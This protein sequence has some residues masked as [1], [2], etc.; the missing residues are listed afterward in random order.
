VQDSR[1]GPQALLRIQPGA[2]L[3]RLYS[4]NIRASNAAPA[5]EG[6]GSTVHIENCSFVSNNGSAIVVV[7]HPPSGLVHV[8]IRS[9][10]FRGNGQSD[11]SGG[12][13]RVDGPSRGT[14][15]VI[16]SSSFTANRAH[17][18]GA[19]WVGG[20][21]LVQVLRCLFESNT[22]TDRGGALFVNGNALVAAGSG[23][24]LAHNVANDGRSAFLS[25]QGSAAYVLP[26]PLGHW[27]SS[28]VSCPVGAVPPE[29]Q[30]CPPNA[31]FSQLLRGALDD[32]F[33][34]RCGPGFVGNSLDVDAQDGPD[35]ATQ[36]PA[37][38]FC[39]GGTVYPTICGT[40]T[41]CGPGSPFATLCPP[42]TYGSRD[43]LRS[44][45]ECTDCEP[46]FYCRSG[47]R[48]DCGE[49]FYNAISGATT[50][51]E[52]TRCPRFSTTR[53]T[54]ANQSS[55]C[56]C[57][58]GYY[59]SRTRQA[60]GSADCKP[61]GTGMNCSFS[62]LGTTL[63]TLPISRGYWRPSTSSIDIRRCPDASANCTDR[64]N[65]TTSG[66]RGGP[67]ESLYCAPG[68]HG[69]FCELCMRTNL[70][71]RVFYDKASSDNVARCPQCKDLVVQS[72]LTGCAFVAGALALVAS[73]GCLLR[74]LPRDVRTNIVRFW[75]AAKVETK[76]KIIFGFYAI[77]T[78]VEDVYE[79][80]LPPKVQQ[81]LGLF[82][83]TVDLGMDSITSV[84]TC[85]DLDGFETQLA[86]WM[87]LPPIL[88]GGILAGTVVRLFCGRGYSHRALVQLSA[89][90]MLVV[91]F[92]LYPQ[93]ANVAF[94][95]FSCH[96]SLDGH[97]Y[98]M[99]DV[100]IDCDS[101][102][103]QEHVSK[104]A[105]TAIAIYVF[106]VFGAVS[107]LLFCARHAV[108]RQTPT[109][110]SSSLAFLCH[111]KARCAGVDDIDSAVRLC[112]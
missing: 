78:K 15:V 105:S 82:R 79:V 60:N 49:G 107:A 11:A 108:V 30:L 55:M 65:M 94:K 14:T 112:A 2:P 39:A 58:G 71:V 20:R 77:V 34:F 41:Y 69:P 91:T 6:R 106:G 73:T 26:A 7:G 103:Y 74:S 102:Y 63:E 53:T 61:C 93:I 47:V 10:V 8:T 84:L 86:F 27:V 59:D 95:A 40:S 44:A 100:A 32:D 21:A 85:L 89:H 37:G 50:F 66:C 96:A 76:F 56:E 70:T 42:G 64:C 111:E 3:V 24:L 23:T 110:L 80:V 83:V 33:P 48:N 9:C 101:H 51:D 62:S 28:T 88:I 43:G 19:L 31:T 98:L 25:D 68:L 12:A 16:D 46:G 54:S 92:M 13:I 99:A 18:G 104:L 17:Q 1:S 29:N 97:R 5:V 38:S 52:C 36:C 81:L 109:L 75:F 22:A 35:C 90:P 72:M 87:L 67:D 4:L 57:I 45:L